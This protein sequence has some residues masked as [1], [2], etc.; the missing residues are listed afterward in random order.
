MTIR[1]RDPFF[2]RFQEIPAARSWGDASI[3]FR[4]SSRHALDGDRAF[5]GGLEDGPCCVQTL[6]PAY[7]LLKLEIKSINKRRIRFCRACIVCT[8]EM[9]TSQEEP[10]LWAL[11]WIK[12]TL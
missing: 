6:F 5:F 4:A 9:E 2:S 11:T 3:V 8:L 12:E 1:N 10:H 7:Y